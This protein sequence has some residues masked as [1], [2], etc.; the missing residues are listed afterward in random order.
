[1]VLANMATYP[2]RRDI[3]MPAVNSILPQVDRLNIYLNE[4]EEVPCELKHYKINAVLGKNIQDN[5]KFYFTDQSGYYFTIDD[6]LIYPQDYVKTLTEKLSDGIVVTCH[7]KVIPNNTRSF[8][9][10]YM[11]KLECLKGFWGDH[12]VNV[13]G[14]GCLA[15]H[16]DTI[17]PKLTDFG[18]PG[19]ADL[20]FSILCQQNKIPIKAIGHNEGW[21]AY[22][23][24]MNGK[25]TLWDTY[26]GN[27]SYQTEVF[28]QYKWRIWQD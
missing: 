18:A 27:D 2:K 9:T 3:M 11:T 21:I 28:N 16:T 14:T 24:R 17:R 6:D 20:W 10:G 15:F 12:W 19:M 25:E 13:A 1:M 23:N 7:G 8:L 5:G 22:N 26:K 4:Y